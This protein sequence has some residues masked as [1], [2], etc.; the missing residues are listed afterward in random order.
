MRGW[1]GGGGAA[2]MVEALFTMTAA[3]GDRTISQQSAC[4]AMVLTHRKKDFSRSE[5]IASVA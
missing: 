5:A 4:F 3:S 1:G 2:L